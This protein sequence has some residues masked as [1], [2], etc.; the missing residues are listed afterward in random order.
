MEQKIN[1]LIVD[2]QKNTRQGLKAL[3]RFSPFINEIYEARDG[4]CAIRVIKEVEPDLVI[5]D[6]QMP[7]INGLWLAKWIHKHQPEIRVIM[8]TMY[9]YYE[10]A[11]LDAGV[12][13]FLVKGDVDYILQDEILALFQAGSMENDVV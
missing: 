8:L 1:I 12:D 2:Y 6:V 9:P 11:A 5:L 3:L 7:V 13:R 4:E 10:E